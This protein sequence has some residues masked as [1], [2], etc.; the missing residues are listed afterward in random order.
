VGE[1]DVSG[2]LGLH[3][4][5]ASLSR[6]L[7]LDLELAGFGLEEDDDVADVDFELVDDCTGD[8]GCGQGWDLA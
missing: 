7:G 1:L 4:E 3:L 6:I 5:D 8:L 2:E